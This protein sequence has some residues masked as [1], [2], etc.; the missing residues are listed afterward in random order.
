MRST[1]VSTLVQAEIVNVVVL[2]LVL[3]RDLGARRSISILRI[4]LPLILAASIIPMF[5]KEVTTHG[6]G[7]LFE[8]A[9][10]M[11][12]IIGGLLVLTQVRV[13]RSPQT[14][15]PVSSAGLGYATV[16]IMIIGARAVF[17]YGAGH[18]YDAELGK[19]LYTNDISVTAMTDG[20]IFMAVAML[21]TRT[22]GFALRGR[23][24]SPQPAQP[25]E[26]ADT[27]S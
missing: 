16:W 27:A 19:W 8:L 25:A 6:N 23:A 9:G 15:K 4:I 26:V 12:G 2:A 14:G 10:V 21:L 11:A 3:S 7:L 1:A 24:I 22:A 20:L 18:W 13:Y 17:S 5:M